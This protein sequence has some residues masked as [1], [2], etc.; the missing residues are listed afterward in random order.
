MKNINYCSR[1]H[2]ELM[3][4]QTANYGDKWFKYL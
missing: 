3:N 1:E 2:S 4:F